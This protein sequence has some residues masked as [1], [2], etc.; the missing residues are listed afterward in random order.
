MKSPKKPIV[1]PNDDRIAERPVYLF[2]PLSQVWMSS[3]HRPSAWRTGRCIPM[4]CAAERP[5]AAA[6]LALSLSVSCCT[7]TPGLIEYSGLPHDHIHTISLACVSSSREAAAVARFLQVAGEAREMCVCLSNTTEIV[8]T[9]FFFL[10]KSV[11]TSDHTLYIATRPNRRAILLLAFLRAWSTTALNAIHCD[12]LRGLQSF[13]SSILAR[14]FTRKDFKG[15]V[16][17][18]PNRRCLINLFQNLKVQ[19]VFLVGSYNHLRQP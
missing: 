3:A 16:Q 5:A 12:C 6:T 15:S 9:S 2:S 14:G 8:R 11:R 4:Q 7:R 17:W 13:A 10:P 19:L 1:S 18:L